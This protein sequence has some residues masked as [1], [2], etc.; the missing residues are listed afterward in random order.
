MTELLLFF[1][2][3]PPNLH[4]ERGSG[5][6]VETQLE[7]QVPFVSH[8]TYCWDT[9]KMLKEA[10]GISPGEG[11]GASGGSSVGDKKKNAW[12]IV[13]G[14]GAFIWPNEQ[15]S[16]GG[17]LHAEG[18]MLSCPELP[19]QER[20]CIAPVTASPGHPVSLEH[21]LLGD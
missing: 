15:P 21:N 4:S 10:Y 19:L 16:A 13:A 3:P 14:K 2:T 18:N 9:L 11:W 20:P 12:R 8:F 1:S 5:G 6:R 17:K 7:T